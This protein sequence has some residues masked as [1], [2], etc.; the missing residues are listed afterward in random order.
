MNARILTGVLPL[1]AASFAFGQ[2]IQTTVN[3]EPV[4]MDVAPVTID[5]RVLV[6]VRGVFEKMGVNVDWDAANRA[7]YA[8][9]NGRA[10]TLYINKR[11]ATVNNHDVTL[12]V[13]AMVYA[14]RTMVPLRFISESMGAV[15]DWL[16]SNN[17][18]A[19]STSLASTPQH[20]APPRRYHRIERAGNENVGV[21][22]Q[23]IAKTAVLAANTVV[24]VIMNTSLSSETAQVGDRFNANVDTKDSTSYMGLPNGTIVEGHVSTV[25]AMSGKTPGVLGLAFDRFRFPDGRTVDIDGSLIGLDSKS[26][27]E[28]NGRLVAKKS[29]NRD[30]KYV[31]IGAGAG[32]LIALATKG[33]VVTNAVIGAALGYLYG[34]QQTSAKDVVLHSGS[35]FGVVLNR[36]ETIPAY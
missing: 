34:Q 23:P 12:D 18:V 21:R 22:A 27:A 31:G 1:L 24:P 29:D 20:Y 16:P 36:D 26:V 3:G 25:R 6:P 17:T 4:H 7:V 2:R 15:V 13:P 5:G 19:I 32:A 9:G 35:T 8:T 30:T 10:V 28:R 33:N 11:V 14:G